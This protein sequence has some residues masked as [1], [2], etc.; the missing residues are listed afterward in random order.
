MEPLSNQ[1]YSWVRIPRST[2]TTCRGTGKHKTI[3]T[4]A[5]SRKPPVVTEHDC[6]FCY[7][8]SQEEGE[9]K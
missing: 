5:G 9:K 4:I 8:D 6:I 1:H 2:C 7:P 3:L